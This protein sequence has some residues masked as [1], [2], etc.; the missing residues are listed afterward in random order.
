VALEDVDARNGPLTYYPGSHRVPQFRSFEPGVE[1]RRYN[2]FEATQQDVMERLGVAPVDLVAKKGD[3]LIWTSNLLHGG[4]P[5]LEEGSTR[6]SQVTHYFFDDCLYFQPIFSDYLTGEIMLMDIIDLNTLEPVGHRYGDLEVVSTDLPNGRKRLALVDGRGAEVAGDVSRVRQ[7][8]AEL[9]AV[10]AERD[11][12]RQ[13]TSF[14]L[15][16]SIVGPFGRLKRR[17]GRS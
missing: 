16:Q 15:G 12:L 5:I 4:R 10:T 2:D 13:S 8:E 7:L 1:P 9:A 17:N 6:W 3:A 11:E 14:R